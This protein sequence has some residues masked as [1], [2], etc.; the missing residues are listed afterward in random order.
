M[1][2]VAEL[3]FD[4]LDKEKIWNSQSTDS[5]GG[6]Q[7]VSLRRNYERY[8]DTDDFYDC[9]F[10]DRFFFEQ[11][12]LCSPPNPTLTEGGNKFPSWNYM[13]QATCPY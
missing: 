2:E 13:I 8:D 3:M 1:R 11:N 9:W 12:S 10:D 4:N 5:Q 6:P 7:K